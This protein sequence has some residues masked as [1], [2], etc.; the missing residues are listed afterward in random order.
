M[1]SEI[2][3]RFLEQ[4]LLDLG[5]GTDKFGYLMAAAEDLATNFREN[6]QSLIRGSLILLGGELDDKEPTLELCKVAITKH[7]QTYRS[8]FPSNTTQL[9]RATLLQALAQ[10]TEQESDCSAAAIIFYS[11]N[12]LLPYLATEREDSIFREFLLT[13]G[14]KVEAEATRT[15]ASPRALPVPNIKYADTA[16]PAL[17]LDT[18][19]LKE[20]LKN[21]TGPAGGAG[22]NPNWPSSNSADWLEHFGQGSANAIAV[23][24]GGVL[25]DLV[26]RIVAQGRSD[27]GIALEG[28]KDILVGVTSNN[29][30]AD[31][32]YW[33]EALFSSNRKLSYRTISPDGTLYWAARELHALVPQFHPQSAEFFLRETVRT[34]L[35]DAEAQKELTLEQFCKG[36]AKDSE[37]IGFTHKI[38][39]EQ[40]LTLL[41]AAEGSATKDLNV[42]PASLRT[43]VPPA[44]KI[45]R[46]EIA[47]WL[48][49]DLQAWR[50]A[51]G[52]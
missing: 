17:G 9:F 48:F 6:R 31:M 35:G 39:P 23:A 42:K 28:L 40:R 24:V 32:L 1:H 50:L 33:K 14:K 3:Q 21:A 36:L 25:K 16:L 34:A 19:A 46:E 47:V 20:A 30:R 15:W 7:W 37:S 49:R 22:A 4:G 2:L 44:A 38:A 41:E 52:E 29:L 45:P 11:T 5:E 43:G 12:G 26:P 27:N 51:G 13:L 8:R 10:I 18:K